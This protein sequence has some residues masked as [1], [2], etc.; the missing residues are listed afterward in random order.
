MYYVLYEY[1]NLVYLQYATHTV[2]VLLVTLL[3]TVLFGAE[4]VAEGVPQYS[5]S[6]LEEI[7]QNPPPPG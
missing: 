1:N 3:Y 6:P 7:F 2:Y 4:V 5:L